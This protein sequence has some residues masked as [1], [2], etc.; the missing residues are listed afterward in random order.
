[1][2]QYFPFPWLLAGLAL[3]A[4]ATGLPHDEN[5][6]TLPTVRI[7]ATTPLP[8]SGQ[9]QAEIPAIVQSADNQAI[10]RSNALDLTEFIN[11]RLGSVYIN[12]MQGNP[13]Q[14]DVNFRGYTASPLLG[15][16]QGISVYLD[17]MRLN[18]PFGDVVSWDLIPRMA[19][20]HIDLMPG[21]DPIFGLNTLGGALSIRTRDGR[22]HPGN[23]VQLSL[24]SFNRRALEVESGGQHDDLDWYV[25]T[26]A[27]NED[28]WRDASP[29]QVRQLF[30]KLGWRGDHTTLEL[31]GAYADNRLTGNG[32]QQG[33]LLDSRYTSVY[34]KP[35]ETANRAGFLN[36]TFI[37]T[38]S[39]QT[40]ISGN[41]YY[42]RIDTR[43][44]NGD[45]NE[46]SLDQSVYQPN[47]AERAALAAAGYTGFPTGGAN[48]A[49]TPFPYWR[50]IANILLSDEPGEKCNGLI[51]RTG[52]QQ[53][54]YGASMQSVTL[55]TLAGYRNRMLLGAAYD[56]S[57]A[58]FTQSTQLGYLTPDRGVQ[59]LPAFADGGVTGG[60]ID[61]VP[62]DNRV[63]M[64]G[65]TRTWSLFASDTVS[66]DEHW[67][68]TVSGRYNDTRVRNTDRIHAPGT[69]G[70]LEGNH[71]F[72][73]INPALGLTYVDAERFK[74]YLGYKEGS[75]TP[76]AIELGCANPA[77]PCRLPNSMAGDPPLRQV[78]TRTWEAGLS[79]TLGDS[80]QWNAGIFH[81]ISNDDIL[82]VAAP[83]QTQ[84]GYFRNFG[85]TRRQGL[86]LGLTRRQGA[87]A[88]GA[89][90]TFLDA[91]YES[92]E[93]MGGSSNSSNDASAPG[94]A[95]DIRI[96]PG[97]RI[98]LTPRH[99]LKAWADYQITAALSASV[100]LVAVSGSYARGNE[101][102][103]HQ[104]DGVYY[105]GTGRVGGYALVHLGSQYQ[106]TDR[107]RFFAQIN[108]LFDRHYAT[109]AQ[110]GPEGFTA[111]GNFV[112]RPF[113]AVAGEYPL[114]QGIF[115][116]PGT[117]RS[118][119]LGIRYSFGK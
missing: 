118:L 114:R 95:G 90:Y 18:Q 19:I 94:L 63:D 89:N 46:D 53:E 107:L 93:T 68:L 45:I 36:L 28:G 108:N 82:F 57:R 119:W 8:A 54:N 113:P 101:N 58:R 102:N 33:E 51:N 65:R 92:S 88:L 116:A 112:A 25:T 31:S 77:Q 104:A 42:R 111:N 84:F 7:V 40:E 91:T 86:E 17:G 47:T 60:D 55:G 48:A 110:L 49:N 35:D 11:R 32:L 74:A 39:R 6:V 71:R 73:R 69:P 20:A 61:G 70:S 80:T 100:N 109:G 50:C 78:I 96:Q 38:Q 56:E 115:Y 97:N 14:A 1:M 44:L 37:H 26:N 16:P 117:P 34:T 23:T 59:G 29:S 81:A 22:S 66:L 2:H 98:P 99:M 76:T 15:T 12:A 9:D 75:R 4:P 52:L 3:L 72:G 30:A 103:A 24:G 105:T 83:D 64:D 85:Q 79:G 106:A 62:F 43:T 13:F 5:P 21:A 41:A 10:E 27:M 87:L 67:H